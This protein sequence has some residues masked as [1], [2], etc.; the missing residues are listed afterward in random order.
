MESVDFNAKF[1]VWA[2][3]IELAT[4]FELL[5]PAFIQKLEELPFEVNIEVVDTTL[6]LYSQKNG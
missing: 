1:E 3:S 5:H 6:Y 4:S 2:S